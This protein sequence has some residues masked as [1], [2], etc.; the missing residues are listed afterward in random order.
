MQ[1]LTR[2]G[3]GAMAAM[4]AVARHAIWYVRYQMDGTVRSQ[5]DRPRSPGGRNGG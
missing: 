4:A 1:R 3:Q 2:A 5:R